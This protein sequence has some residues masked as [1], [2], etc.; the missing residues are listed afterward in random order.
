[1]EESDLWLNKFK[2]TKLIFYIH[3]VIFID[4]I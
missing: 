4:E 3:A 1:M 2:K